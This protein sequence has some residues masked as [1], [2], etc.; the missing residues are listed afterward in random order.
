MEKRLLI[1]FPFLGGD[2]WPIHLY[3]YMLFFY[4]VL[5]DKRTS[6]FSNFFFNHGAPHGC[7]ELYLKSIKE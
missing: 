2:F 6:F 3:I 4:I 1:H 5:R 7:R